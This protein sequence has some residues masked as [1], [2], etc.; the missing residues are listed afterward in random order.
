MARRSAF[1]CHAGVDKPFARRLYRDLRRFGIEAWIDEKA[2]AV[3][4]SLFESIQA[5]L[6]KSDYVVVVLS[7][8]TRRRRWV[9]REI[10]A[11]FSLEIKTGRKRIL[12]VVVQNVTVPV[13]LADRVYADFRSGYT[14]GLTQLL[15]AILPRS[16]TPA[17]T[18]FR[19]KASTVLL[20]FVKPDGSLLRYERKGTI[21][22]L[23]DGITGDI[24]PCACDGTMGDF[25]VFPG[26]ITEQWTE[27][28][29]TYLRTAFP[30]PL[31]KGQTIQRTFRLVMKNAFMA[32]TEWWEARQLNPGGRFTLVAKFH[33]RRPPKTWLVEERE[34]GLTV[35]SRIAASRSRRDGRVTLTVRV[36][37]PD[38][39]KHYILRWTW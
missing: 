9:Q 16:E 4:D 35:P 21:E 33:K 31:M 12:P 37:K 23:R 8:A 18:D 19:L 14:A 3:G 6:A 15:D 7:P 10:Q 20:D 17:P 24:E 32:E 39:H 5:G 26:R 28:G 34:A 25:E 38:L 2:I 1:I 13:L 22:A 30:R 36:P 11:A 29:M 27:F